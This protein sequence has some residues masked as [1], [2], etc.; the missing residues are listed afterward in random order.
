MLELEFNGVYRI[1]HIQSL[2]EGGY[3]LHI[4]KEGG[5]RMDSVFVD[6]MW[7]YEVG[8]VGKR[9]VVELPNGEVVKRFIKTSEG[10]VVVVDYTK[11]IVDILSKLPK[12]LMP[13]LLSI[14]LWSILFGV[15]L[16]GRSL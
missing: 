16:S 12:A 6:N 3:L 8:D 5:K 4:K 2:R 10:K 11:E 13:I 7:G 15:V 14:I 9:Y 1:T